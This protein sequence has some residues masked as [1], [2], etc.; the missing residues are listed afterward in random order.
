MRANGNRG[1]TTRANGNK[2]ETTQGANGI[3]GETIRYPQSRAH[4]FDFMKLCKQVPVIHTQQKRDPNATPQRYSIH[5]KT[6]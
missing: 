6:Y 1:E 4:L 2:G 3:R 5:C